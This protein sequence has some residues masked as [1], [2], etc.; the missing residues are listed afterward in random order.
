MVHPV[1]AEGFSDAERYERGRPDYADEAVDWMVESMGLTDGALVADVGAGTGKLTRALRDRGCTVVP[2]EPLPAMF[3]PLIGL[4]PAVVMGVAEALPLADESVDGVVVG[5]AMHWFDKERAAA[6][7]RRVLRPG[8]RLGLIWNAR[9]RSM[10]YMDELWSIMDAI[11]KRAPWRNHDKPLTH[12]V[13]GF[14]PASYRQFSSSQTVD[15]DGVHDR[16]LSVSHVAA[17]PRDRRA[18]V[19][20]AVNGVLDRHFGSRADQF[21]LVYDVDVYWL[22]PLP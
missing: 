21:E 17:L 7:F 20:E 6:E 4:S 12:D 1:A 9:R 16:F 13:P 3:E 11:E 18:E 10:P 8:G 14:G 19:V 15:R 2:V 22:E 5:Q